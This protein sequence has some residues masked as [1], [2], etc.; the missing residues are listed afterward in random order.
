MVFTLYQF[1]LFSQ[2]FH[3]H[4]NDCIENEPYDLLFS[5]VENELYNFLK[6]EYNVDS[7]SEYD[8]MEDYLISNGDTISLTIA[9]QCNL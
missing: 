6:S 8:C 2:L 3:L 4:L 9:D 7:K 1:Y 5:I